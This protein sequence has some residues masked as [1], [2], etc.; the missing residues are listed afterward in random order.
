MGNSVL[1]SIR[2]NRVGMLLMLVS[3]LC[4]AFG[5]LCWKLS[6]SSGLAMLACGFALYAVGALLMLTAFRFGSLSVLQ[7]MLSLGYVFAVVIGFAFL[8]EGLS[9]GKLAGLL[10]ILLGVGLI[11]AGD[12]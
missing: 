2:K 10:L 6:G 4:T 5:Q 1:N 7:P 8:K 3:A 9:P 11:G 12:E